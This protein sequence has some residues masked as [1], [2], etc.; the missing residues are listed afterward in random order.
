MTIT[1]LKK[2]NEQNGGCFFDRG[3]MK[4]SGDTMRGF[5]L[6]TLQDG[7]IKLTRKNR[8]GAFYFYPL[9]GRITRYTFPTSL[10]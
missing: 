4:A 9:T 7:V 6:E 3:S 10:R 8:G 2:L 5:K 1:E